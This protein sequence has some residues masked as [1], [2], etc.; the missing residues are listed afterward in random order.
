MANDNNK[1]KQRPAH[2]THNVV[3]IVVGFQCQAMSKIKE[4]IEGQIRSN[5]III[6]LI[7]LYEQ[8]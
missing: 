4:N 6:F 8:F 2:N 1:F 7:R 5:L 3:V